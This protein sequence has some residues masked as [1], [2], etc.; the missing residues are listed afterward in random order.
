MT[1]ENE[2]TKGEW[3]AYKDNMMKDAYSID[4]KHTGHEKT[5]T[6]IAYAFGEAN[7]HLIAIAPNMAKLLGN[8]VSNGW[9]ASVSE[10]AKA[11]LKKAG[12]L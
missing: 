5:Y 1:T 4:V 8:L 6:E 2:Y 9:N 3:K 7:A 10:E 11:I 12:V